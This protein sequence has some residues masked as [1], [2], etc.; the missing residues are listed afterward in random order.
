MKYR[1]WNIEFLYIIFEPNVLLISLMYLFINSFLSDFNIVGHKLLFEDVKIA[2]SEQQI[3]FSGTPF[4]ILGCQILDCTHGVNHKEWRKSK[5][6]QE[7][8]NKKVSIKKRL[9]HPISGSE[10]GRLRKQFITSKL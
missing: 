9:N 1:I 10:M 4:V 8:L 3:Q 6:E 5:E 2:G 7:K